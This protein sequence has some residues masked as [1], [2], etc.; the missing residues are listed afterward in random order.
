METVAEIAPMCG[1][2]GLLAFLCSECGGSRSDLV[3]PEHWHTTVAAMRT[4]GADTVRVR[5]YAVGS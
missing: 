3:S 5:V 2:P 1:K 4:C